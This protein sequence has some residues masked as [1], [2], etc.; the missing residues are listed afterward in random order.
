LAFPLLAASTPPAHSQTEEWVVE[1][2]AEERTAD[3]EV[4]FEVI[5]DAVP[6]SDIE[7][8]EEGTAKANESTSPPKKDVPP[9][10][11]KSESEAEAAAAEAERVEAIHRE[12]ERRKIQA[13]EQ[14]A[15]QLQEKN[16]AAAKRR[17]RYDD[18]EERAERRK[19]IRNY[20]IIAL[21]ACFVGYWG[22]QGVMALI[23]P[24]KNPFKTYTLDKFYGEYAKDRG[25]ADDKFAGKRIAIDG[26]VKVTPAV[27]GVGVPR[28]FFDVPIQKDDMV[29][30]IKFNSEGGDIEASIKDGAEY[31][32]NGIV[33]RYKP[34]SGILITDANAMPLGK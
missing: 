25:A 26:K 30:E 10:P 31:R 1:K 19:K 20:S 5:T 3:V 12:L 22:V 34:G 14:K 29:V 18:P 15:R 33:Q 28:I 4:D 11:A 21:G 2:A 17:K 6:D 16:A 9:S 13:I 23:P 8:V 7:V 27:G 24:A 32:I